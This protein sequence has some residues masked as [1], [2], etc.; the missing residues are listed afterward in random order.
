MPS[1]GQ[2]LKAAA[3][4][5]IPIVAG[6][7]V[8]GYILDAGIGNESQPVSNKKLSRDT[9]Y[10]ASATII[11]LAVFGSLLAIRFGSQKSWERKI[12]TI[13]IFFGIM[14]VVIIHAVFML[15]ACC[16]SLDAESFRWMITWTV[17]ALLSM[18]VSG[19]VLITDAG[20]K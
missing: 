7:L 17:V 18:I 4:I 14:M 1:I 15:R 11:G 10:T 3:I 5:I 6:G 16:G 8:V 13:L 9:V 2:I 12:G 20:D 19:V